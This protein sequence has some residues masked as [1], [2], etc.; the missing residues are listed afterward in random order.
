MSGIGAMMFGNRTPPA[1]VVAGGSSFFNNAS[2]TGNY[3]SGNYGGTNPI[4]AGDFTIEA[5][6]YIDNINTGDRCIFD[7]RTANTGNNGFFFYYNPAG[8][9]LNW[10]GLDGAVSTS[11]GMG[12]DVWIHVAAVRTSGVVRLFTG[13]VYR[14]ATGAA[15]AESY[16][17]ND[18]FI[19]G[20]S[21]D[22]NTPVQ[23][24]GYLD[25][26]R[27]SNNVRYPS[28]TTFTPPTS[29]LVSD[30]NTVLLFN[31]T[32]A[33]GSTSFVDNGPNNRTITRNGTTTKISTAN[34]K[35]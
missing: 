5:W 25:D 23:W 29:Q 28:T 2:V 3:L 18:F 34:F 30:A 21:D 19:S 32:G 27:F 11:T 15:P 13:G 8:N 10:N 4:G 9:T 14:A 31:F 24:K 17:S 35:F 26:I 12:E 7:S 6:M 22:K 33:D 1:V 16:S 20:F